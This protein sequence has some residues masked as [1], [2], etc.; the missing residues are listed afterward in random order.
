MNKYYTR[1]K[2]I[3]LRSI[4]E[5]DA[6]AIYK[7]RSLE[8]I[9]RYQYWEPFTREQATAFAKQQEAPVEEGKW[10]G[11]AIEKDGILAGDC[12]FKIEGI[13][14]EVG[15]NISPEYQ[16]QGLAKEALTL[17]I[18][19]LFKNDNIEE[20][21]GIT[22]SENIASIRLLESVG[23]IKDEDFVNEVMCKGKLSIEYKYKLKRI[24]WKNKHE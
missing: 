18:N 2:R 5:T 6:E 9:A 16:G 20:I 15:C 14:A 10:M 1:L 11:L 21:I 22:D 19:R 13:T 4:R 17:L 7:Y 3:V 12:A 23:M 8:D 24:N